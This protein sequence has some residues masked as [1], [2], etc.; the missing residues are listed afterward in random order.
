VI[1]GEHDFISAD[2]V[3]AVL[4]EIEKKLEKLTDSRPDV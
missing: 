1:S 2:T 4:T 3:E